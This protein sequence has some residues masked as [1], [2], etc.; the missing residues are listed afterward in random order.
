MTLQGHPETGRTT[1]RSATRDRNS[2]K[3]RRD[4]LHAATQVFG[5]CGYKGATLRE[6]GRRARADPALIAR[7][8]GN[9]KTLY[10]ESLSF[11]DLS[12]ASHKGPSDLGSLNRVIER[13]LV[14]GLRP[15]VQA[16]VRGHDD[17]A[18]QTRA[19][20]SVH[21][22]LTNELEQLARNAGFDR[23]RLRAQIVVAALAGVILGRSAG[24]LD[25]LAD[26]D[27]DRVVELA[28]AL[29]VPLLVV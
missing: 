17:P 21:N 14:D 27:H 18:V 26:A 20:A 28:T 15:E 22:Q 6:I 24:T 5:E 4:L 29:L 1:A 13:L 9:K 8:F 16:V 25:E 19:S 23:P 12:S 10:F 7:Y 2:S 11:T 3:T